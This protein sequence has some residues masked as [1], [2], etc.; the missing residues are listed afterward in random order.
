MQKVDPSARRSPEAKYFDNGTGTFL[1]WAAAPLFASL[2]SVV[3]GNAGAGE[4]G[5]M[6]VVI[7]LVSLALIKNRLYH[8]VVLTT[9]FLTAVVLF[10]IFG[11]FELG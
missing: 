2:F 8:A 5:R 1:L 4:A 9:L 6:G 10:P 11:V 3:T 7:L